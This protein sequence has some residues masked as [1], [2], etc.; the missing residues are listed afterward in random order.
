MDGTR[1]PPY[2]SRRQTKPRQIRAAIEGETE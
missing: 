2:E 1:N